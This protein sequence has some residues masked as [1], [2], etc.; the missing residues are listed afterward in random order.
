VK[1]T[2]DVT[3]SRLPGFYKLGI[4]ER[5]DILARLVH[6]TAEERYHLK[7]EPLPLDLAEGMVENVIGIFGLPLGV[8]VNFRINDRDILVPMAVEEPSV[9]AAA[10]H[11]AKLVRCHG[12]LRAEADEPVMIG[13]VQVVGMPDPEAARRRV[14][15]SR[16]RLLQIANE[17]DPVL[18]QLGGGARDI[19]TRL[20][21]T[22][23]GPMLVVH[24]LVDVRDAMGA[25]AVNTMA[26]A[27][28]LFLEGLTGGRTVLRI[29][30]NLADHRRARAT[31]EISPRAFDAD[32][33]KGEEVAERI[34]DAWALA[35]SDPYR[36][37]THNKGIM[38]GI[39]AVMVATGNDWRA[40]EAGAHAW[41]ARDGRY[42]PLS[43]WYLT[44][45]S[46]LRG[47][48]EL[49]LAAGIVGGATKV[50][51]V[52]RIAL[53][54]MAVR[55]ARELAEVAAAVGLVQNLAALRS[56]VTDG[57]QKGHMVLHA[58]NI[59]LSAGA[60]G[61]L[62]HQV[63]R[64]MVREGRIRFDRAKQLVA[65]MLRTAHHKVHDLE[66]GI[67]KQDEAT[68]TR[69]DGESPTTQGHESQK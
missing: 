64:Q 36:A 22:E 62:A 12:W 67:R 37:A 21:S 51:P 45:Q 25:N 54:L 20:V 13:Q 19:E 66:E 40:I 60:V 69:T 57:I 16:E 48:I 58:R 1:E 34:L 38:N 28:A 52:A 41:A 43:R 59:A 39:D 30:S 4:D 53:K 56:L 18:R 42:R 68:R 33:W 55:T 29:L 7:R 47:E 44:P 35:E 31:L 8:A 6:L 46:T 27:V 10:S 3:G 50:H 11:Y 5:H 9:V 17:Q 14:A 23:R 15:E 26:E 32:G 63:A 24:L 2:S 61:E 65:Q 49:P